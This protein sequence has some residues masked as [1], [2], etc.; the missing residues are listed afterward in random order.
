MTASATQLRT[1]GVIGGGQLAWMMAPAAAR[2]GLELHIQTPSDQ[3]PAAA[4][5]TR[6][7]QAPVADAEATAQLAVGADVVTFENEFVD[8][9]AL[10][11]LAHQGVEFIPALTTL[12]PLLDKYDQRCCLRDLG[13]PVPEF[14]ALDPA[15]P[16]EPQLTALGFP[17][18][19]KARRLGYDG[20]GTVISRSL[21]DLLAALE[22]R[23]P[24]DFL[25]EAFVPFERELAIMAGRDRSGAIATYPVVETEQVEQ[26]CRLV[27]APADV[28]PVVAQRVQAIAERFLT[29]LEAVGI[30]GIELFLTAEGGISVNEVAPRTH[31]SGHYSLDACATSQFEQ[32]LRIVSGLPLGDCDLTAPGAVMVNLL[33]YES[34]DSDYAAIRAQLAALP[35][36]HLYWYGKNQARPGRKL[37]H[38]TLE[39]TGPTASDCRRQAYALADQVETIWRGDG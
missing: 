22:G 37:G 15:R 10:E 31:N 32:Q 35:G 20:K 6:L 29:G 16:L 38:I 13:L 11:T 30:F 8:L 19:L 5:A 18:V 24:A 27:V 26:V 3:D 2:L 21:D 9:P 34:R 39:L 4:R 36:A 28:P 25:L 33:G 23:D 1:I 7:V 12:A 17:V 14:R